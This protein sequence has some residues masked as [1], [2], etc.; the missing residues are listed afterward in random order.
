MDHNLKKIL[1]VTG[2]TSGDHHGAKVIKE[3]QKLHP[4]IS[5]CG[6]G[7]DELKKAGT[8]LL[9]HSRYLSVIGIIEVLASASHIFKAFQAVKKQIKTAPP[10]L[11]ILIDYP[12]F[13]L[14][15]ASIAHKK[16][17]PVL[18]YI[19]PQI[20]AWRKGRAKKIARIVD[21]MAVIF[22]FETK[23]YEKVGLPVHFVGH[24]LMDREVRTQNTSKEIIAIKQNNGNPVIGLLPGSRKGEIKKLLPIMLKTA[25]IIKKTLPSAQFIIPLAPGIERDFIHSIQTQAEVNL[26]MTTD[27][28]YE[29]LEAC[30]MA[31]VAS[32]TAT[33]ET[34]V[35]LK[36]M[37][38]IYKVSLMTYFIG[39]MLIRVP[40]IG[41]ANLVAGKK[42]VPELIQNDAS[43][44]KIAA[45]ATA[46]L[47]DPRRIEKIKT[48]LAAVKK[49]L[50]GKGASKK[51]ALLAYEMIK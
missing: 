20:W 13:N 22:P 48:E 1:I 40:F 9:Y 44:E 41:L 46:I 12:D 38:I 27:C 29:T 30:D 15:I 3:L 32:G 18:Y 50:G 42:V 35:M 47:N 45:E 8:E 23:F 21:K 43:P 16:K 4:S 19:S 24:P 25:G 11:L 26:R 36:P 10:D 37:I 14:R 33:L 2:E 5:I 49:A 6:I 7:G 51:V 28:F 39:K 34:A 17:I 31:I